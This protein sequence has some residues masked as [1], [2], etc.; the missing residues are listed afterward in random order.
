MGLGFA[1][2]GLGALTDVLILNGC[3]SGRSI[4]VL[5]DLLGIFIPLLF[6]NN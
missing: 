6:G 4:K 1:G 3:L 2:N 5:N